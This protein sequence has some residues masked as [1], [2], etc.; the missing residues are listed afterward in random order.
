RPSDW[1]SKNAGVPAVK[2][3]FTVG[4]TP[5]AKDLFGLYDDTLAR[6]LAAKGQ[7]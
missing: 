3:P 4:G 5:G 6:L 2:L 7:P 1:L